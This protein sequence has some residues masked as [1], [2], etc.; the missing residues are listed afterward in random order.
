AAVKKPVKRV[1]K[2]AAIKKVVRPGGTRS[3]PDVAAG[4][5]L[6][7][8]GSWQNL[9]HKTMPSGTELLGRLAY[10]FYRPPVRPIAGMPLV[11]M[12]HGCQQTAYDLALGSRMNKLADSKGFVVVYPQ[13]VK[14][15][16][17][18]RCWRWF[19]PDPAHG[20]GEAD[21]IADLARTLAAR[22]KLDG[23]R[24]YV[25][26]MS[27]G[28]GMAGLVA[29]RHPDL[30]A[31]V[32]MHSGAVLGDA[33]SPSEGLQTMRRG[34]AHDP[35]SL[36]APLIHRLEGGS[37]VPAIILHGQRDH[38]V[39]IR[40]ADQL[41][42]QFVYL[43]W[44]VAGN[45]VAEHTLPGSV[46]APAPNVSVLAAGTE[47]EYERRDYSIGRKPLVRLCLIKNV[48]HGW[49]GG[50]ARLKFNAKA[51]PVACTLIWQFFN[52]HQKTK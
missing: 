5:I 4:I 46:P 34:A 6:T 42:Q 52:M 44:P 19:Q 8:A 35:I 49:S 17:A 11:V 40:N 36:I 14:R 22:Y 16:H 39:A 10:S 51:G 45:T 31:A 37:G 29:V 47:R 28:A 25:A 20:F 7:G 18:L 23:N 1:A 41:A 12:L 38:L 3:V 50:D 21:A 15:V 32:A 2:K 33:R 30:V 24:V 9:F 48:G 43:N 26:G 13:Q 27:A